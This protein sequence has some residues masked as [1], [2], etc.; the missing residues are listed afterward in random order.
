MSSIKLTT[1]N[2]KNGLILIMVLAV[3][4]LYA[5]DDQESTNAYKSLYKTK[6]D[7]KKGTEDWANNIASVVFDESIPEN[8]KTTEFNISKQ[9]NNLLV[10]SE[11]PLRSNKNDKDE[12]S[13]SCET[14]KK[15]C[16]SEKCVAST[17][18]EILG[19]GD[20]DVLIKYERKMLSVQ[21]YY[22]Y[23]DCQ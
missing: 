17:L 16:R 18:I 23:Q 10:N 12:D 9:K 8:Q 2:L 6:I 5:Q 15:T 3:S 14:V 19:D 7:L 13:K 11:I 22:T 20:R 21:I 1:M 4:V